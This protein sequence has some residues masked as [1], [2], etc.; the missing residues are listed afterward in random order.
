M[1]VERINQVVA[2]SISNDGLKK[3]LKK[4]LGALGAGSFLSITTKNDKNG[5]TPK[6]CFGKTEKN[7]INVYRAFTNK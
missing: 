5:K 2:I 1:Q 4:F 7:E 6:G 3:K